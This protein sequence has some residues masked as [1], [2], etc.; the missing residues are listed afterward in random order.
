[1]NKRFWSLACFVSLT[2]GALPASAADAGFYG[3][4]GLGFTKANIE[5]SSIPI[6][7]STSS[8]LSTS[9]ND[10]G[11]KIFGGYQFNPNIGF[12]LGYVDLGKFSATRTST[13]PVAGAIVGNIRTSGVFTNVVGT[14]PLQNNFSVIG[15]LGA[16][17]SETRSN[18]STSG[19][20]G[21]VAGANPAPKA[22]ENNFKFGVG[23]QYD[24]NKQ[25]ALR[26][27]W[28]RYFRLGNPTTTGEADVDMFSLDVIF[29]F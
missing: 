13:A 7:G 24:L 5:G 16:I 10:T 19:G 21:L 27:E 9:E 11:Y 28:D 4:L 2:V 3:G 15:K 14:F 22:S 20:I 12:E 18:L 6:A 26:G 29:K 23:A 25:F 8:N 1:M 17:F